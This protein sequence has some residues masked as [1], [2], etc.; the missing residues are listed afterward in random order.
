MK[1]S[2]NESCPCHS[3]KKYKKCCLTIKQEEEHFKYLLK[4]PVDS[5]LFATEILP[6][7]DDECDQALEALEKNDLTNAKVIAKRLYDSFPD[8]HTVNYLQGVCLIKEENFS[9]SI[10]YFEKAIK[11]LIRQKVRPFELILFIRGL[12]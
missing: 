7:V 3:G 1:T 9:D 10:H 11:I 4:A 12:R 2:R 8:N 6:E 5:I